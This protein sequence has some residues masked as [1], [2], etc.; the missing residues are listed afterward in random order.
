MNNL[1]LS[2]YL[3]NDEIVTALK[4]TFYSSSNIENLK[5]LVEKFINSR[6]YLINKHHSQTVVDELIN[7][8]EKVF[9]GG[10]ILFYP[11]RKTIYEFIHY[12]DDMYTCL[13]QNKFYRNYVEAEYH[14]NLGYEVRQDIIWLK[15]KLKNNHV[16]YF[17]DGELVSEK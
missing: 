13:S 17:M 4:Q 9:K 1:N 10:E 3:C 6:V 12:V 7:R 2:D 15:T 8:Y 5:E 16:R 14:I 11:G